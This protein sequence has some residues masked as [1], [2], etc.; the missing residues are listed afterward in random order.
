MSRRAVSLIEML[1]VIAVSTVL[2]TVAVTTLHTLMQ[3]EHNGRNHAGQAATLARLADQFR[4]DAH[5]ALRPIA[6]DG[7]AGDQWQFALANR[8]EV[9]YEALPGEIQRRERIAGKLVRQE[10]YVLPAGSTAK[11][12]TR[13]DLAP[14]MAS[15][16][17]TVPAEA[18]P[19]EREI[20]IDA[21]LGI[22]HRFTKSPDGRQ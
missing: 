14:V 3:A 13:V 15:L 12:T 17:I 19:I 16:V 4:S 7:E 22:D 11:I 1:V 21:A 10:S 20:R 2:M 9:T 8:A 18:P 5:A 6:A